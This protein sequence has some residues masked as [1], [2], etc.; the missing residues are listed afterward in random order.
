MTTIH[1][2]PTESF[3]ETVSWLADLFTVDRRIATHLAWDVCFRIG[4][5]RHLWVDEVHARR[6]IENTQ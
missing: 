6:F 4:T 2:A 3:T 5:D 1:R